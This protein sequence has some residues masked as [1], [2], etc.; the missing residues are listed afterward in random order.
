MNWALLKRLILKQ[1]TRGELLVGAH[2]DD[3]NEGI[4]GWKG[5]DRNISIGVKADGSIREVRNPPMSN[6][7]KK[8]FTKEHDSNKQAL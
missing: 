5:Y 6:V 4:I 8:I 3:A 2:F 1:K 7:Q